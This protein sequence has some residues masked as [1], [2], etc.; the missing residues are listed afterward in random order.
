[1][2]HN[3]Q[4]APNYQPLLLIRNVAYPTY[5]LHAYAGNKSTPPDTVLKIAILE[6][7]QWLRQRFRAFELPAELDLP[8]PADHSNVELAQMTSFHLD[9]GYK[10]EVIW[11][12]EDKIWTLQLTEPDLGT[13]PGAANQ[14]RMPVPGRLFETNIAYRAIP[15]GVE[16]GFKTMVS[17]PEDTQAACEVFRLAFIKNLARNPLVGLRQTWQLI[18]DAHRLSNPADIKKL[19][20]WITDKN[21]MMPAAQREA[22]NDA[23]GQKIQNGEIL[24]FEPNAFGGR[25][26]RCTYDSINREPNIVKNNLE[27]F[28][29]NYPKDKKMTFGN[30]VFVPQAKDLERKKAIE[31]HQSVEE[32]MNFYA[33]KLRLVEDKYRRE[34]ADCRKELVAKDEK[35][36]RLNMKIEENDVDKEK[37]RNE[38]MQTKIEG[39]RKLEDKDKEILRRQSLLDRPKK[40]HEVNAWIENYFSGKIYLHDKAKDNMQ[41]IQPEKVNIPLLCDAL[42]YLGTEYRDELLGLINEEERDLKC[43]HKYNRRFVVVP[44]KSVSVG[45]YPGNYKIKYYIGHKGKPVESTLDLHLKVG[46]DAENL[47]RIYFLYDSDKSLIVI[48]SLPLHLKTASYK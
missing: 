12:P 11:L 8:G 40:P 17:E 39:Q 7:M 37:L 38:L 14:E 1:M 22:F 47:L 48:G 26:T 44:T 33:E 10:L 4:A 46:N 15:N 43:S 3:Y 41:K 29:Q 32:S 35:I 36:N 20:T 9:M 19:K 25:V 28:I 5:Q 24:I 45:M 2:E 27:D 42:E 16:C 34:F 18:D 21:R 13:R 23:A 31:I 6:T 30:C